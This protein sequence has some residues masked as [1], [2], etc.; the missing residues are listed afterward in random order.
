MP[1]HTV[2]PFR[3][4]T[5]ARRT[6]SSGTEPNCHEPKDAS[7]FM[8]AFQHSRA[9]QSRTFFQLAEPLCWS[10]ERYLSPWPAD[11]SP[12]KTHL[13]LEAQEITE[14]F[15]GWFYYPG[16]RWNYWGSWSPAQGMVCS[17]SKHIPISES[18]RKVLLLWVQPQQATLAQSPLQLFQLFTASWVHWKN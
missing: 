4:T 8:R 16:T 18:V 17:W 2:S 9:Q 10:R 3:V 1:V 14:P 15:P 6:I 12:H 7:M 13:L 11:K 5:Q